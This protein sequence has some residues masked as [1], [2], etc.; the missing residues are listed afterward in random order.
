MGTLYYGG[1]VSSA[2]TGPNAAL[3]GAEHH[4]HP[5]PAPANHEGNRGRRGPGRCDRMGGHPFP[6]IG[7]RAIYPPHQRFGGQ[8]Y[9]SVRLKI[10]TKE[11]PTRIHC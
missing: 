5:A 8:R 7:G 4:L 6:P 9:A 3:K 11:P 10:A 2:F 1:L